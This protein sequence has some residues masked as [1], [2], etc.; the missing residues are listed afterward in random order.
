[1]DISAIDTTL[2]LGVGRN[3]S[4]GQ[5]KKRR[6]PRPRRRVSLM[7][8]LLNTQDTRAFS[9][10]GFVK[11]CPGWGGSCWQQQQGRGKVVNVIALILTCAYFQT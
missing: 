10:F 6:H 2:D 7:G 11:R 5:K 9:D 1:V 4:S 3:L 8:G